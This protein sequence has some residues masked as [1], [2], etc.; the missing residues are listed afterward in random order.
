VAAH[1]GGPDGGG[2]TCLCL[3]CKTELSLQDPVR[4]KTSLLLEAA[5][6]H[7]YKHKLHETIDISKIAAAAGES[8]QLPWQE[9]RA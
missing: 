8:V 2:D 1:E 6:K 3:I 5:R 4:P 7:Y 9:R